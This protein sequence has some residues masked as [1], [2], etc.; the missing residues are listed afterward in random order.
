VL[1]QGDLFQ[2][3]ET[4][5]R[6]FW[7]AISRSA[8]TTS[9]LFATTHGLAPLM[10]C[11]ARME[12]SMTSSKRLETLPKQS[13][14]VILAMNDSRPP[15]AATQGKSRRLTRADAT[16]SHNRQRSR[17]VAPQERP[18]LFFF[19]RSF[20]TRYA[21]EPCASGTRTSCTI[22]YFLLSVWLT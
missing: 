3:L 1:W 22:R 11:F 18:E 7:A 10:S 21:S 12:A 20:D 5:Q 9:R 2:G 15:H 4:A 19:A 14:T 8:T 13:S 16:S 17:G 6:T